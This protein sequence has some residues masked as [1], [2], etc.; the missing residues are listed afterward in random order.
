MKI[1]R[2]MDILRVMSALSEESDVDVEL[3]GGFDFKLTYKQEHSKVGFTRKVVIEKE[4][5][6]RCVKK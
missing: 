1:Y 3:E 4:E 2:L 6:I 5:A